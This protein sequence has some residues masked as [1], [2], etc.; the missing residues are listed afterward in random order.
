[1]G[2][3]DRINTVIKS[4]VNDVLD[5]MTDPAKE[6]DLLIHDM[7][8][9]EKKATQ[10][11][12]ESVAAAKSSSKRCDKM[13]Q[14]VDQ[15]YERAQQAVR[16]GDDEL[17]R[18]ALQEKGLAER[19]LHDGRVV[20]QEQQIHAD[21]LKRSLKQLKLKIK[22]IKAR[23]GTLKHKARASRSG[24]KGLASGALADFHRIEDRIEALETESDLTGQLDGKDAEVEA[25][26]ARLEQENPQVED[27]LAE[28][29]RKMDQGK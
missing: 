23:S 24:S 21:Q 11:L 25:K 7:Q 14:D 2:I 15:W 3:L 16:A 13:Q 17:A 4:N 26:F 20:L 1:M 29:K 8:E 5:K 19:R 6:I 27:A 10:E 9:S 18:E 28:L 22:E 12:V